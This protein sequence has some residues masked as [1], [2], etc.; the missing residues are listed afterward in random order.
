MASLPAAARV[1]RP[2]SEQLHR[3]VRLRQ[4]PRIQVASPNGQAP[5]ALVYS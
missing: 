2:I 5:R 3:I 1:A 4:L